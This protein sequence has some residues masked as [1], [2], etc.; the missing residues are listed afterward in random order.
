MLALYIKDLAEEAVTFR[1]NI[2]SQ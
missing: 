2:E 1:W